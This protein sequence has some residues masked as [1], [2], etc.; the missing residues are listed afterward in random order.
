MECAWSG[1]FI[2]AGGIS[3]I[4]WVFIR[5]LSMN[6]QICWDIVPGRRFFY[7]SQALGWGVPAVLFCATMTVTGVSFR[8]GKECD[9]NHA[10]SMAD[11][12]GPLL[13]LAAAA[14]ILQIMTFGFCIRVYLK[15]LFADGSDASTNAS[16]GGLPSYSGSVR[17]QTARAV[18]RRLQKVLWLQ[19]RGICIVTIILVDVIFFA[20][21]FVYLDSLQSKVLKEFNKVE[22]WLLCLALNPT[23]KDA[24][25]KDVGDWIVNE[26]TVAAVLIL[27][28]LAGMQVFL[29]LARPTIASAWVEFFEA[30]VG[31]RQEFVSLDARQQDIVRNNSKKDLTE[32]RQEAPNTAF[33]MHSPMPSKGLH[34]DVDSKALSPTDTDI[35]SPDDV[36]RSPYHM[37]RNSPATT[38]I[39]N[40]TSSSIIGRGRIPP[41]YVGRLTP[42]VAPGSPPTPVVRYD[43]ISLLR[44]NSDYFNQ[45]RPPTATGPP[46]RA[47]S[48]QSQHSD[49]RY[50]PPN[51]SFSAPNAPSRQS[52]VRSVTFSDPRD[53][54]SRGGLALNPPSEAGESLED[55]T[56]YH[57]SF[58][59]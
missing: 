28:S 46:Q 48:S 26:A 14:G 52:S 33:E 49:R 57:G 42:E 22:P 5:A 38:D 51:S 25:L 12:W 41:E 37:G 20:I 8:F 56:G 44:Q 27:L 9:V 39:R 7:L 10:H 4:M 50:N 18:W 59:R 2:V 29:F 30:K 31:R 15:N 43:A 21:V 3:A 53:T 23:D 47:T 34:I 6:L 17:T 32:Y 24:C 36:Y 16:S 55:L 19:W 45:Q 13:A 40:S 54:Y 1:A 58:G 11:F 35:T